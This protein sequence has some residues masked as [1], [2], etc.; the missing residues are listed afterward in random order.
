MKESRI[1][2]SNKD[3]HN[4]YFNVIELKYKDFKFKN[5]EWIIE[6]KMMKKNA[7]GFCAFYSP[8]CGHCVDWVGI[9]HDIGLNFNHKNIC[10]VNC[11]DVKNDNNKLCDKMDIFKYPIFFTID[12]NNVLKKFTQRYSRTNVVLELYR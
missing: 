5:G 1:S 2:S 8:T 11:R 12:E 3:L 7:T 4:K 9:W 6:N 10:T